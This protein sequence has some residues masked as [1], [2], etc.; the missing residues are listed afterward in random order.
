MNTYLR[1][2]LALLS[3]CTAAILFSACATTRH[4]SLRTSATK[5]DDASSHFAAQIR[6]QGDDSKRDRVSRDAEAMAKATHN[7]DLALA[8]GDSR[9]LVE[10]HYRHVTDSYGLLHS[11]L[12]EEGYASQDKRVLESFDRVTT[13]YR[14]VEAAMGRRVADAR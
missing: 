1:K 10:D 3:F 14:S 12:A 5:L 4:E 11:Q 9:A 13:T 6:Y 8:K 2:N 7:L